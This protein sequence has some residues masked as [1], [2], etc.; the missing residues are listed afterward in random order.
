MHVAIV[1]CVFPPEP[2]VSSRTSAEIAEGLVERGHQVSVIT[3]FPSRPAGEVYPGFRRSLVA[4]ERTGGYTVTRAFSTASRKSTILSRVSENVTFGVTSAIALARLRR[5]DVIFANTWPLGA[6]GLLAVVATT[7]GIPFVLSVQDVYPESL[8][9]QGRT[10]RDSWSVRVLRALDSA[11]ARRA[12]AVVV[13]SRRFATI[14]ESSRA[15]RPRDI[16]VVPNWGTRPALD[17]AGAGAMRVRWGVNPDARVALYGGNIGA[18]AGVEHMIASLRGVLPDD[19]PHIVVAGAGTQ[20]DAVRAAATIAGL[21]VV[22]HSPW[23][24]DETAAALAA[25]DVLLLPTAGEQALAS[26]PSKLISYLLAGRPV[27]AQVAPESETAAV[28]RESGAGWVVDPADGSAWKRTLAEANSADANA[29]R[30]MGERGRAYAER[31][32]ARSTCLPALL[33][34]IEKAASPKATRTACTPA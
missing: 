11:I 27:I 34:I 4:H 31:H 17:P 30:A 12:A 10:G 7:R 23:A 6:Q 13:I 32:M 19:I 22:F 3:A 5:P 15:V 24:A 8:I 16:H 9:A 26:V 21:P 2:I 33:D 14:Y 28:M 18:A 29:L 25:A 20:L 1:S